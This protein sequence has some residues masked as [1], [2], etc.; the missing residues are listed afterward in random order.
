[1]NKNIIYL[2]ECTHCSKQYIV[3][4]EWPPNNRLNNYRY[5]I[6]SLDHNKLLPIEQHFCLANHD[7]NTY[8]RF[9]IIKRI[10]K[11]LFNKTTP[12]LESYEDK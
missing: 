10:E 11:T 8:A 4:S 2:L 9:T 5:R 6:K 12:A 3:K 1:M 7:F